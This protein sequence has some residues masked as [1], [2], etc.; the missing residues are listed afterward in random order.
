MSANAREFTVLDGLRQRA[1]SRLRELVHDLGVHKRKA[2]SSIGRAAVS[3]TAGWGFDALL[4][5]QTLLTSR[6]PSTDHTRGEI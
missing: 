2:S 3:K 4:A 5:C 1:I 6:V